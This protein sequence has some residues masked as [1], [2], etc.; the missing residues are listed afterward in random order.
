M[1]PEVSVVIPMRNEAPN[2][3]DLY[4]ELTT[5]LKRFGR[6]YEIIAID[7]GSEDDT[8]E[9]LVQL[10]SEDPRLEAVLTAPDD[11][12]LTPLRV[13]WLPEPPKGGP[14]RQFLRLLLLGDARDP[15]FAR[16]AMAA[17]RPGRC[18]VVAGEAA[19]VASDRRC[20]AERISAAIASRR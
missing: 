15:G 2:V 18:Q 3:E 16:Q 14:R 7:D 9:R 11:A 6:P 13:A 17:G 8:F 4:R 12:M 19:P 1:K 5:T 20:T 10:Q